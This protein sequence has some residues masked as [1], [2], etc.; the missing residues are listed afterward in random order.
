MGCFNSYGFMSNIPLM[1]G[2]DV[3]VLICAIDSENSPRSYRELGEIPH[4]I[5]ICFPIFG[6]YDEYGSV[7]NVVNDESSKWLT[8]KTGLTP[9][10]VIEVITNNIRRV[11]SDDEKEQYAHIKDVLLRKGYLQ[12][13]YELCVT[14][15]HTDVYKSVSD[16]CLSG[17]EESYRLSVDNE[18]ILDVY[19]EYEKNILLK[20][21]PKY[22]EM[23]KSRSDYYNSFNGSNIINMNPNIDT[24]YWGRWSSHHSPYVLLEALKEYNQRFQCFWKEERW[25]ESYIRFMAFWNAMAQMS[26]PITMFRWGGQDEYFDWFKSLNC[27]FGDIINKCQKRWQ[28]MIED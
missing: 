26:W 7:C 23:Q 12:V 9:E 18:H 3:F 6:K 5:P 17:A 14:M 20:E 13:D 11:P 10:K 19:Y 2:D 24:G 16:L 22:M 15:D 4:L 8:E 1:R 25:K 21:K 27:S 28:K